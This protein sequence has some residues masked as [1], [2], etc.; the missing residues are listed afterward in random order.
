[1]A[2][3]T[4]KTYAEH[5]GI[6]PQAVSKLVK[7]GRVITQN[8]KIDQEVSD[9][10]LESAPR[11]VKRGKGRPVAE[12]PNEDARNAGIMDF[13]EQRARHT[14]YKAELAKLKL[15]EEQGQ[16][17][18]R[19]D[20]ENQAYECAHKTRGRILGVVDRLS[21]ILAAET[22]EIKIR[23]ILDKELRAALEELAA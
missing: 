8:G 20:V 18:R 14:K 6:S 9:I 1:M 23:E 3:M 16:L 12:I 2:L 11:V 4:Q 21:G 5:R 13:A 15:E 7:E 19:A 17:V 10:L 22:D